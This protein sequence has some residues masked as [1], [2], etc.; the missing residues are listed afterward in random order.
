MDKEIQQQIFD[1]INKSHQILVALPSR[2]SG[3]ALGAGLAMYNFL[4]KLEKAVDI[5]SSSKTFGRYSFLPG[6]KDIK[7]SLKAFQSFVISVFTDQ[8]KLDEI[9]HEEK[10]GRIDIYLKPKNGNFSQDKVS[11]SQA[12]FPYD[13]IITIDAPSLDNLGELYEGNTDLF[14]ETPVVNIDHHPSNEHFGEINGVDLTA[15]SSAEIV[16]TLIDEFESGLIDSEIATNLLLGIIVE[17]NSFQHA[18]TTPK[19]FMRASRL[20][21]AGADQQDIIKQLYKTKNISM[22]KLWGRAM[23]R[24]HQVNEI[25]FASTALSYEDIKKTDAKR[26]DIFQVMKELV[27]SLTDSRIVVLLAEIKPGEIL[28]YFHLHPSIKSEVVTSVVAGQ[29]LDGSYGRFSVVGKSLS[30][31]HR[32]MIQTL[33]ELRTQIGL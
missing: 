13:L 33:A 22:L 7:Q 21:S 23:A 24:I 12:R 19:A 6:V 17:T 2:P 5:A 18:K 31:A 4:R 20:I 30:E 9:S 16:A 1:H 26:A 3:D 25:G 27:A 32:E 8:V 15:T 10:N 11:F 28:G 14:F 29:M